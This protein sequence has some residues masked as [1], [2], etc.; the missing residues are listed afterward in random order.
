MV[1]SPVCS[2]CKHWIPDFYHRICKAFPDGIPEEIWLGDNDH[3]GPYPGDQGIR[4]EPVNE[5][6]EKILKAR[7]RHERT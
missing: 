2:Y 7:S 4:F 5:Q 6:V 1:F 3:Q